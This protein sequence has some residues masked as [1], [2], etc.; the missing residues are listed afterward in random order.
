MRSSAGPR[1]SGYEWWAALGLVLLLAAV[2][3]SDPRTTVA[4]GGL[5]LLRK[6]S[7]LLALVWAEVGL[8]CWALSGL[9]R[10]ATRRWLIGCFCA[11][12]SAALALA[13]EGA[14][15]CGCLGMISVSPWAM[16]VMD[17]AIVAGLLVR[18]CSR[19]PSPTVLTQPRK[20]MATGLAALLLGVLLSARLLHGLPANL[21]AAGLGQPVILE[22]RD[23]TGRVF[24]L[25]PHVE[26]QGKPPALMEGEWSIVLHRRGC[27]N[28]RAVL[29]RLSRGVGPVMPGAIAVVEF[30]SA[31]DGSIGASDDAVLSC[32]TVA[33]GR[34]RDDRDWFVQ[35]PAVIELK[36]GTVRRVHEVSG[37]S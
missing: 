19:A 6:P 33:N 9:H 30:P 16:F 7:I 24:P 25:G 17:L 29:D 13:L 10:R 23:W 37:S 26:W 35:T 1:A 22:P 8:G 21:D 3:K 14:H 18:P 12:G 4:A 20:A 11:F 32:P 34:I 31:D 5:G 27:P 15:S 36:D 2:L 28:C